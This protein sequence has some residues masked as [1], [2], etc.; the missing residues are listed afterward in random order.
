M[1]M[2]IDPNIEY[3]ACSSSNVKKNTDSTSETDVEIEIKQSEA[4][5]DQEKTLYEQFQDFSLSENSYC[6]RNFP[7]KVNY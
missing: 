4:D 1:A 2:Q 7:Q 6:S 5:E 3:K